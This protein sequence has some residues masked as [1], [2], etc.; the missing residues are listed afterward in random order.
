M[1]K[2]GK[3]KSFRAV[4]E[5]GSFRAVKE[6]QERGPIRGTCGGRVAKCNPYFRV[7]NPSVGESNGKP[8]EMGVAQ[9]SATVH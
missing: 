5:R 1:H 3:G 6:A 9:K 2:K 8:R 7:Y 4:N